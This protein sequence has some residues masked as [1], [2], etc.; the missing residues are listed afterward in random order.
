[1]VGC[2]CATVTCLTPLAAGG[3]T[4]LTVV[5]VAAIVVGWVVL[6]V[7]YVVFFA[8]AGN[9]PSRPQSPV[10]LR[11]GAGH[12]HRTAS[13]LWKPSAW[14]AVAEQS[15]VTARLSRRDADRDDHKAPVNRV[16]CVGAI[17]LPPVLAVGPRG[18]RRWAAAG[19][20][21]E[22]DRVD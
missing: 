11:D 5:L 21:A 20:D 16:R 22:A 4:A 15:G 9:T 10:H 13:S 2:F 7:I 17:D 1:V 18:G 6:V 8:T 12:V 19:H 14:M 3:T